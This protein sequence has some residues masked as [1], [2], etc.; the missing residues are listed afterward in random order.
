MKNSEIQDTII[1]NEDTDN[2]D[3][4]VHISTKTIIHRTYID[5]NLYY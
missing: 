3:F 1:V 5:E 4:K 2:E